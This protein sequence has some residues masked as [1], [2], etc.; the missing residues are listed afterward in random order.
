MTDI[1]FVHITPPAPQ[2]KT[3]QNTITIFWPPCYVLRNGSFNRQNRSAILVYDFY[4]RVATTFFNLGM[5]LIVKTSLLLIYFTLY[6]KLKLSRHDIHI[7]PAHLHLVYFTFDSLLITKLQ[8]V[9]TSF[10][11][12]SKIA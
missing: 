10:R 6:F 4:K 5:V 7:S 1:S 11:Q 3:K 2:K 9:N 8:N 12:T